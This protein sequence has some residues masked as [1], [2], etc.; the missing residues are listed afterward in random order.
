MHSCVEAF[1]ETNF[2][3]PRHK[4]RAMQY[5]ILLKKFLGRRPRPAREADNLTVQSEP[6]VHTI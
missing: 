3:L 6:I 4:L 1:V 5:S 2:V